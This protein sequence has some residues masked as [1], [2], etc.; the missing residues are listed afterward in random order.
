MGQRLQAAV[1]RMP[2]FTRQPVPANVGT[3][4]VD[5]TPRIYVASVD[6]TVNAGDF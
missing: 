4:A 3:K 6:G 2:D 1:L 5:G